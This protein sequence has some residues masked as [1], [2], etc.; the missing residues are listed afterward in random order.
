MFATYDWFESYLDRIVEV[1]AE[2]VL[3]VAQ[4]YL[5]PKNRVVGFYLPTGGGSHG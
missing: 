4:R 2:Q 1:T 5:L 3:E